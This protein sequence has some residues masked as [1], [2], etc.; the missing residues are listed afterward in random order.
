MFVLIAGQQKRKAFGGEFLDNME[1][2]KPADIK[3][4]GS[5]DC[6]DNNTLMVAS[7]DDMWGVY[8][9]PIESV[10]GAIDRFDLETAERKKDID[11]VKFFVELSKDAIFDSFDCNIK[12]I[13]EEVNT[14]NEI[15]VNKVATN[16]RDVKNEINDIRKQLYI[17]VSIFGSLILFLLFGFVYCM[18]SL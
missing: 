9:I 12:K 11:E 14:M 7:G 10:R 18:V 4:T 8:S 6:S 2:E 16:Y 17:C 13:R 15:L 3:I 1:K 5:L